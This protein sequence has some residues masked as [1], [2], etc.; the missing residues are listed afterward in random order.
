MRTWGD[1]TKADG[2]ERDKWEVDRVG[3]FPPLDGGKDEC[4]QLDEA[5]PADGEGE[6]EPHQ[7]HRAR[8]AGLQAGATKI[9]SS[10][11]WHL[12]LSAFIC[13]LFY[14]LVTSLLATSNLI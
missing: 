13:L 6:R 4:W 12:F 5:D 14:V 10:K 3:I 8:Q 11:R 1:V 2:G 9:R 7:E